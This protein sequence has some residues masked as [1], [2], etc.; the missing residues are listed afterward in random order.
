MKNLKAILQE[1]GLIKTSAM[2]LKGLRGTVFQNVSPKKGRGFLITDIPKQKIPA[3]KIQA[4]SSTRY[5]ENLPDI[6]VPQE[7]GEP[8]KVFVRQAG[9]MKMMV[10]NAFAKIV[11]PEKSKVFL[12]KL[13]E[14][15]IP[16]K[17][18][19]L[20]VR[21]F[22]G[23]GEENEAG[24]YG[25]AVLKNQ[26]NILIEESVLS[27]K[28]FAKIDLV[29]IEY[30][31]ADID[32]ILRTA[33]IKE[34]SP[35]DVSIS[36]K[37]KMETPTRQKLELSELPPTPSGNIKLERPVTRPVSG[38]ASRVAMKPVQIVSARL[39]SQQRN[40][41]RESVAS[42]SSITMPKLE[43]KGV[44]DIQTERLKIVELAIQEPVT[45]QMQLQKQVT[46]K[47]QPLEELTAFPPIPP[48]PVVPT[49]IPP[50]II[51]GGAMPVFGLGS[52][53]ARRTGRNVIR[54]PVP[55]IAEL[56]KIKINLKGVI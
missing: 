50:I 26:K 38:L 36:G 8:I 51:P 30:K 14:A 27:K 52:G 7:K 46:L 18:G 35:S 31:K 10:N 4:Q 5:V 25:L 6:S 34:T 53:W 56:M 17:E 21:K 37:L 19:D 55:E 33:R 22:S 43:V 12:R 54:N 13:A 15:K 9:S 23:I 39:E 40:I 42:L 47:M 48:I 41:Q 20:V 28:T 29:D 16:L 44:K 1:E 45:A 11:G 2:K 49:D 32:D 24:K 3:G